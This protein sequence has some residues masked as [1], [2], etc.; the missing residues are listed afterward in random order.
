MNTSERITELKN[1]GLQVRVTHL[2]RVRVS[3]E[4]IVQMPAGL[5]R[6]LKLSIEPNGGMTLVEIEPTLAS[7]EFLIQR[8]SVGYTRVHIKD[9]FNRKLGLKIALERAT[10]KL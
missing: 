10:A 3:A 7:A 8:P 1:R 5:A 4:D 6:K 2:R 9:N